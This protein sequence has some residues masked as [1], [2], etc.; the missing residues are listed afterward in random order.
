MEDAHLT[1]ADVGGAIDVTHVAV[2]GWL[3]GT[4]RPDCFRRKLIAKWT[5]GKIPEDLWLVDD[6]RVAIKKQRPFSNGRA[7]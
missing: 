5:L 7:A 4:A 3:S 1:A 2:L 6:E